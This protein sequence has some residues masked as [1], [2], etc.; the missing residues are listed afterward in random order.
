MKQADI[1]VELKGYY[2]SDLDVVNAARVSFDKESD[3]EYE[4]LN[5]DNTP[6]RSPEM[7]AIINKRLS[8]K[9]CGLISY[10]AKHKHHSPFNHCFLSF[11]V[12]API[13]VARQLV[14]HKFLPWN[15]VSRRY[16]TDE[17]EFYVPDMWRKAA[18]NVKQGSSEEDFGEPL[19][20]GKCLYCGDLLPKGK[21]KFCCDN[22]QVYHSQKR[23]PFNTKFNRWKAKAK[24]HGIPWDLEIDDLDWPNKCPYLDIE[25]NYNSDKRADNVASL[26]R[27]IP[28]KGYTKGNVQIISNLANMM[29]T[30]ATKDQILTFS[31]NAALIH[32]GVFTQ[33]APSYEKFLEECEKTYHKLISDGMCAEQ[34]R[35]FLPQSL[36]TTWI[37]SGTLGAFL[38]MLK[39]RLDPHTQKETR[40][41]A[42]KIYKYVKELFPVSTGA[43]LSND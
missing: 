11:R 41:V 43:Y 30:C 2:G 38:D 8:K 32:G 39:L 18:Q 21:R 31:K 17:L 35:A 12:K 3:Y 20:N 42:E 27:I 29:K 4:Y 24:Q 9:D 33:Q 10:L 1:S 25:L 16:V 23:L 5:H 37:W 13:F 34:A 15:E 6:A 14:K 28:E 36:L 40:D 26:D 7:A 19:I 22:H